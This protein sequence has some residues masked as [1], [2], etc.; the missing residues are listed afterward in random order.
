MWTA[1]S[2]D[3]ASAI[4]DDSCD[5]GSISYGD[6]EDDAFYADDWDVY[7]E[8][9]DDYDDAYNYDDDVPPELEEAADACEEAYVTNGLQEED[10]RAG[11]RA[12]F[13]PCCRHRAG[14]DRTRRRRWR[15]MRC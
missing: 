7:D 10:A 15:Q 4:W 3:N 2:A 1:G 11:E 5:G 6:F 14:D 12:W 9:G 8:W 13:L